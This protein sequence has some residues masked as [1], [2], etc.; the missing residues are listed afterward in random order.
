MI[1]VLLVQIRDAHDPMA[2]HERR[3]VADRIGADRVHLETKNALVE[4]A[5]PDWAANSDAVVIGGSGDYSVHDPRSARWVAELQHLIEHLLATRRPTFAICFGHQL[6]GHHLGVPVQTSEPQAE[7]GTVSLRLTDH[8]ERDPLFSSLG[9]EFAAH[10]GHS[11]H[12]SHLPPDVLVLAEG[13]RCALQAFKH[14]DAPFYTTQFHPDMTGREA[15]DRYMAYRHALAAAERAEAQAKADRF[16]PD[17]DD[18]NVLLRRFIDL[19][20]RGEL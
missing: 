3:C 8:G 10:T 2:E 9:R 1:R 12:V 17:R 15:H 18:S 20:E 7:L 5:H 14:V 11:D 4:T 6:L 16:H 19:V 13:D